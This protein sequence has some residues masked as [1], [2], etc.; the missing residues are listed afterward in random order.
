M[1]TILRALTLLLIPDMWRITGGTPA[2]LPGVAP[3]ETLGADAEP[4]GATAGS[5]RAK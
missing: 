2:D 3:D 5:N 1:K 4:A